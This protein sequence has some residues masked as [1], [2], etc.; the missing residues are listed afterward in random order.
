MTFFFPGPSLYCAVGS[1]D[2][3]IESNASTA[4]ME[5]MQT[6][7]CQCRHWRKS[8]KCFA[9]IVASLKWTDFRGEQLCAFTGPGD[10]SNYWI[11]RTTATQEAFAEISVK[12]WVAQGHAFSN[13]SCAPGFYTTCIYAG[14]CKLT[15]GSPR[16]KIL[17]STPQNTESTPRVT[18]RGRKRNVCNVVVIQWDI[19]YLFLHRSRTSVRIII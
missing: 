10:K 4:G 14:Q 15:C 16:S 5:I 19:L 1:D 17:D 11:W 7:L 2:I 9:K 18:I 3:F 8:T 13:H 6:S 12:L